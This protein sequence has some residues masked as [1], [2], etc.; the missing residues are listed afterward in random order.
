MSTFL[1]LC[2]DAVQE[3]GTIQGE[4]RPVAVTGQSGRL[5]DFVRWVRDAWIDIQNQRQDW[6]WMFG[7]FEAGINSPDSRYDAEADFGLDRWAAWRTHDNDG[8][9]AISL[10]KTS[11]G[12]SEEGR[13]IWREWD[14]FYQTCLF[15]AN[16]TRTGRPTHFSVDPSG[17]LAFWPTPDAA[18]TVR[19]L[20]RKSPQELQANGDL[21]EMP[22]RF[23]KLIVYGALLIGSRYDEAL[24]QY[25][26][27]LI[28]YRKRM[29]E[30]ERDQLPGIELAGALA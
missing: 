11:V 1:Q 21:P 19:G 6:L 4:T 24:N 26:L 15:G 10:F 12:A 28:E 5:A 23:H 25:P 7:E 29:S 8:N 22:P 17:Q 2:R 3:S 20:Y 18:Y 14:D 13:L 27:W 9:S 16:R 30:L